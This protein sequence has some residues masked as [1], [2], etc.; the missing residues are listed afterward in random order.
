MKEDKTVVLRFR[1]TPTEADRVRT[2]ADAD[3]RNLSQFVR[4]AVLQKCNAMEQQ[5]C[6]LAAGRA[7]QQMGDF[8][9]VVEEL[10]QL[11]GATN[12]D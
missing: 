7:L 12:G 9:N 6:A 4:S 1:V 10:Q 2:F 8:T 11:Q 3:F 5:Q